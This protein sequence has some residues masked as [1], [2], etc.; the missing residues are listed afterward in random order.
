VN[1]N[2]RH[3]LERKKAKGML[4]PFDPSDS[5]VHPSS[6]IRITISLKKD[7]IDPSSFYNSVKAVDKAVVTEDSDDASLESEE[8]AEFSEY[9]EDGSPVKSPKRN[10]RRVTLKLP[11]SP[12]KTRSNKRFV[13]RDSGSEDSE[14][15]ETKL[16]ARRSMR[17]KSSS[18]AVL[19]DDHSAEE[20]SDSSDD[21]EGPSKVKA[22]KPKKVVRGKASRPAYGN[23]RVVAD[24]DFDDCSDQETAPLRFHR[25]TCE[26]C[27]KTPSHVLL[28]MPKT[29]T[30]GRA[31]K[32][33][34]FED[35]HEGDDKSIAA[36]GGWVRWYVLIF[37]HFDT[38]N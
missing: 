31:R 36:L 9:E 34:E 38:I 12:R 10:L 16:P 30:K 6:R 37:C 5:H 32:K 24:L 15:E 26:K 14:V 29:K 4:A 2:L 11:Y 7:R 8:V 20:D 25:D 27:H 23:F 17:I 19:D 33:D 35:E 13:I 28:N 1:L 21:Y 22:E 18:K 3:I